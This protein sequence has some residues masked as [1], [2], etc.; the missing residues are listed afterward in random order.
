M[1]H[2]TP[3]DEHENV[4][5]DLEPV[6]TDKPVKPLASIGTQLKKAREDK[7]LQIDAVASQMRLGISM[8]Q[9][10]ERNQFKDLPGTFIRG[11]VRGYAKLVGLDGDELIKQYDA[12]HEDSPSDIF[13]R[14]HIEKEQQAQRQ[15]PGRRFAFSAPKLNLEKFH[16]LQWLKSRYLIYVGVVVV[17]VLAALMWSHHRS[18]PMVVDTATA[19]AAADTAGQP[20]AT[21]A[22]Q[23]AA[24]PAE[25]AKASTATEPAKPAQNPP[26]NGDLTS[27]LNMDNY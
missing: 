19:P 13:Y 11:Y 24:A 7:G 2:R 15:Q 17:I 8:I 14:S 27:K 18:A 25:G 21:E 12:S 10:I 5:E 20:A 3:K 6:A 22:T 23:N 9:D 26:H 16:V 4:T 1:A